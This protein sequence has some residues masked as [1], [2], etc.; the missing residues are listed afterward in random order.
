MIVFHGTK[1][2]DAAK[3]EKASETF[4]PEQTAGVLRAEGASQGFP[5]A[6]LRSSR[7]RKTETWRLLW[8][9]HSV[10]VCLF[11][12]SILPTLI[13]SVFEG[14]GQR[15]FQT[16]HLAAQFNGKKKNI[17]SE[18][19]L[20]KS[21][22]AATSHV[23]K[24]VLSA[25]KSGGVGWVCKET[26]TEAETMSTLAA[27]SQCWAKVACRSSGRSSQDLKIFQTNLLQKRSI[28][29]TH[30]AFATTRMYR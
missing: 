4:H 24:S 19:R 13:Q 3:R 12:V 25:I 2:D 16:V 23:G 22:G 28:T 14:I 20:W 17:R 27:G 10:S 5:F 6:A 1:G 7:G 30:T 9:R 29:C 21:R 8:L 11:S 15:K 18:K 26:T